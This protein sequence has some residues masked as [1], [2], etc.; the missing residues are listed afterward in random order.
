L[1]LFSCKKDGIYKDHYNNGKIKS[2]S[3]YKK[4]L[5]IHQ[6]DF[7]QNGNTKHIESYLIIK[8]DDG[9]KLLTHFKTKDWYRNGF[10][11]RVIIENPITYKTIYSA[12]WDTLGR[13][14]GQWKWIC[15]NKY[16]AIEKYK[17]GKLFSS[18]TLDFKNKLKKE[19]F[20][21]CEKPKALKKICKLQEQKR[22]K[23]IN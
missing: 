6:K 4:G 5:H 2:I 8:K 17:K 20:V 15:N 19:Y 9:S 16:Y 11:S 3:I 21:N 18:F 1:N 12:Y 22:K 23:H 10:I 14:N 13:K 7:Y